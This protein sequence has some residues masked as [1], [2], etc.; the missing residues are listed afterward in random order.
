M[1]VD[2]DRASCC[3]GATVMIPGGTVHNPDANLRKIDD[4]R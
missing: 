2:A 3:Q 1:Q 4:I